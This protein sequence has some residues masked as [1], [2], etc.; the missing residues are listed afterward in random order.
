M[1][2]E[3]VKNFALDKEFF[4]CRLHKVEC[5]KDGCKQL[6]MED[7]QNWF[8]K[9]HDPD[10]SL[11]AEEQAAFD[12]LNYFFLPDGPTQNSDKK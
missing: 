9:C 10:D 3:V 7:A 12:F 5:P 11:D 6:T 2:C 1:D 8:S 4:Y